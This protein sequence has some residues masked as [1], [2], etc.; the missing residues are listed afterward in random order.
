[1]ILFIKL[2]AKVSGGFAN[3][4]IVD[5]GDYDNQKHRQWITIVDIISITNGDTDN[6]EPNRPIAIVRVANGSPLSTTDGSPMANP[7]AIVAN[8]DWR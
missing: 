1:M 6:G 3:F 7:I 2:L 5:N 4:A 8:G